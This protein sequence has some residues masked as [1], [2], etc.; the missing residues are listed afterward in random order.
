MIRLFFRHPW[1]YLTVL[2]EVQ[3]TGRFGSFM[4]VYERRYG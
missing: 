2:E 1:R 3:R 4:E